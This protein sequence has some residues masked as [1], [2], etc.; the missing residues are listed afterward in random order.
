MASVGARG[1]R[2]QQSCYGQ[3]VVELALIL[4]V[5]VL[6]LA[7]AFDL[8]RGMAVYAGVVH[9]AREGAWV[10][11]HGQPE[12]GAVQEAVSRALTEAGL[13][14]GLATVSASIGGP[15]ESVVVTVTY[16]FEPLL[17]LLGDTVTLRGTEE[18]VRTY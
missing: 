2:H 14:P 8:G 15:G 12:M 18:M 16:P 5:L 4:P 13:D 9:A 7:I 6:L 3:S 17:P 10:A 1:Y 11:A